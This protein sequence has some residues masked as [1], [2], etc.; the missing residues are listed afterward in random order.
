MNEELIVQEEGL[1]DDYEEETEVIEEAET[2]EEVEETEDTPIEEETTETPVQDEPFLNIRFNHEDKALTREEAVTMAQKGMNYD[3]LNT[4][5]NQLNGEIERLAQMNGMNVTDY[6]KSL[7][8]MQTNFAINKEMQELKQQY[9]NTDEALLKEIATKRVADKQQ[10]QLTNETKLK[11]QE[12]E[13]RRNE[14]ERQVNVFQRKYP[15]V[16]PQTLDQR[17]YD[18]M[19]EGYTML[20]AYNEYRE[21][22]A[23]AQAIEQQKKENVKKANENNSKKGLGNVGNVGN[24][25][26]DDFLNGFFS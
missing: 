13:A 8:D 20:E 5:Y 10:N 2:V 12:A 22:I 1:F 9:P 17:V 6:L 26:N 21:E 19:G 11:E 7:N 23:H 4:K 14:I 16:N 18:L 24:V 25:D 15:N 3:N